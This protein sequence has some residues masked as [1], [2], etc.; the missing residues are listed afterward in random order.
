MFRFFRA[1]MYRMSKDKSY[2]SLLIFFVVTAVL[3]AF[4]LKLTS[5][6]FL[7]KTE[8]SSI[9]F[10]LISSLVSSPMVIFCVSLSAYFNRDEK[11]ISLAIGTGI[12]R[13][14]IS[15]ISL[16]TTFI[17]SIICMLLPYTI[18]LLLGYII[19]PTNAHWQD[20]FLLLRAIIYG[21]PVFTAYIIWI[22]ILAIFF[23]NKN[24][25]SIFFTIYHLTIINILPLLLYKF[26]NLRTII[27][28]SLSYQ[29]MKFRNFYQI[30]ENG[31]YNPLRIS[32]VGMV[33]L[34]AGI[35]IIMIINRKREYNKGK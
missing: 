33:W 27:I 29:I 13:Y 34:I 32:I 3:G 30:I 12:S 16:I 10:I 21:I 18:F 28:N 17:Y 20:V 26:E 9:V 8:F 19:F 23:K 25:F 11:N 14:E 24:I 1:E 6:Q 5:D 15:F 7:V 22:Y 31:I 35:I 2:K 4:S